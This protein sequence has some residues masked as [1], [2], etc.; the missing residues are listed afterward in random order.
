MRMEPSRRGVMGALMGEDMIVVLEVKKTRFNQ[1][2]FCPN[3]GGRS[4]GGY[5]GEHLCQCRARTMR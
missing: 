4:S 1:R 5:G 2:N 3:L